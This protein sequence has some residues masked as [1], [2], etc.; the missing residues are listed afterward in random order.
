LGDTIQFVRY[1]SLVRQKGGR[2]L[3]S[4]PGSLSGL[5][6]GLVGVDGLYPDGRDLPGYD[7]QVPLL[8]LPGLLGTNLE[9]IPAAVPYLHQDPARVAAWRQR[10]AGCAGLKVGVAWRG[11]PRHKNDRNRS[12]TAARFAAALSV[13]G[14]MVVSLQKDG[15]A[16]EIEALRSQGPV[17]EAGPELKD[18]SD[19]AAV[20]AALDLVVSVDTSVCHLA[21]ALALPVWTLVPFSPD[22]RWLLGRDDSPW[23]P[24]LRLFRQ[25]A[26]GDWESVVA[27]VAAELREYRRLDSR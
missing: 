26:T 18:F 4:C 21:G 5:F 7:C 10:L 22:W 19:T 13:P 12:M 6:Q 25:P 8:S 11:N 3:L 1:A 14:L 2:V 27:A 15:T 23:Y 9:T 17:L 24:T 16:E 20:M